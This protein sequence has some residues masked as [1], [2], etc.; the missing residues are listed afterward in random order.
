MKKSG[1]PLL[2][3][4]IFLTLI[5]VQGALI[6]RNRRC[7]CI[8]TSQGMI[9]L[10]SLKELKQFA[11][12]PSCEKTE[13]IATMKNGIQTCLNPDSADVKK[14]IKEWEK[15]VSQKKKQRKWKKSQK[16]RK[17]LKVK[18]ARHPHQK[19]TA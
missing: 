16:N 2:L 18:K 1:I 9:H 8:N 10:K 17:V 4:V 11:P 3:G 15:Q 12:S 5:G 13:I 19:K 7:F 14:L 6:R